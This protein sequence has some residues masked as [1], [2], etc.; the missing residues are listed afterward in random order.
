MAMI[1]LNIGDR[2]TKRWHTCLSCLVRELE[3]LGSSEVKDVL[4]KFKAEVGLGGEGEHL[5]LG[6][7][8]PKDYRVPQELI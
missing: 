6:L 2:D 1:K 3:T 8:F 4:D 7:E 5:G